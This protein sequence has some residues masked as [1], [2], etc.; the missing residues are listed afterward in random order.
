[1]TDTTSIIIVA[2]AAM[3]LFVLCAMWHHITAI[4]YKKQDETNKSKYKWYQLFGK[5]NEISFWVKFLFALLFGFML[6][7][8]IHYLCVTYPHQAPKDKLDFDYYGVIM[9]F[10]GIVVTILVGWQIYNSIDTRSE[11]E[12]YKGEIDEIKKEITK[13]I[14]TKVDIRLNDYNNQV[15]SEVCLMQG[16]TLLH[17]NLM[18]DA[19][20]SLIDALRFQNK[21]KQPTHISVILRLIDDIVSTTDIASWLTQG[22]LKRLIEVVGASDVISHVELLQK[23]SSIEMSTLASH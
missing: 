17:R 5:L 15:Q 18:H 6:F 7:I 8:C 11:M 14:T 13:D 20:D 23:L 3:M 22:Q 1:M 19:I 4:R 16:L 9:S 10:F 2:I 12:S 21:C